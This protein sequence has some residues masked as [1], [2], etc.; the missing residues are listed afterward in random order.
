MGYKDKE[1]VG[2]PFGRLV[3]EYCVGRDKYKRW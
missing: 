2:K 1:L 3:V